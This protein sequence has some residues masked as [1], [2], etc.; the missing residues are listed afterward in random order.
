MHAPIFDTADRIELWEVPMNATSDPRT[1][2]ATWARMFLEPVEQTSGDIDA[3]VKRDE[4]D[5]SAHSA[6]RS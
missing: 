5:T 3:A 4:G 6:V 2:L 1:L